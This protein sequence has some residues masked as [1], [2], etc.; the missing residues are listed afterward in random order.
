MIANIYWGIFFYLP[1]TV[2]NTTLVYFII[3]TILWDYVPLLSSSLLTDKS[4]E[5]RGINLP[6]APL[7]KAQTF[8]RLKPRH[9]GPHPWL[10]PWSRT[11]QEYN[12]RKMRA[13][14]VAQWLRI[15]LPVQVTRVRALVWEDPTCRGAARPVS[16]NCWACASGACALQQ[17]RPR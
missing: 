4:T 15:C 10:L 8:N 13:S 2:L 12:L 7:R 14:L 1:G 17:E 6:N 11:G 16:H 9:A 3:I 5:Y